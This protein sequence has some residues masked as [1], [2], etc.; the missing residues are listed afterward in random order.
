MNPGFGPLTG[1]HLWEVLSWGHSISHSRPIAP[2]SFVRETKRSIG[3]LSP[4]WCG[5]GFG[6][7]SAYIPCLIPYQNKTKHKPSGPCRKRRDPSRRTSPP[8]QEMAR[9]SLGKP[10]GSKNLGRQKKGVANSL[11]HCQLSPPLPRDKAGK[12][13]GGRKRAAPL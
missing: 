6:S 4:G 2:A 5:F 8:I 11:P 13:E 9:C 1:D 3:Q 7:W 12:K 10:K